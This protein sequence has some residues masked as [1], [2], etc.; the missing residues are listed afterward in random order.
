MKI[1]KEF[2]ICEKLSELIWNSQC[3]PERQ[4][5]VDIFVKLIQVQ[6][7]PNPITAQLAL[8]GDEIVKHLVEGLSHWIT[9]NA[10][11]ELLIALHSDPVFASIFY[12]TSFWEAIGELS[13]KKEFLI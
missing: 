5:I 11:T 3:L 10:H 7:N 12:S 13:I 1:I 9:S 4:D 6:A 8:Q 2:S